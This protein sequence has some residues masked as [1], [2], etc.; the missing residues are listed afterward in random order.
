MIDE[1]GRYTTYNTIEYV[2][3]KNQSD[4]IFFLQN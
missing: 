1:V 2:W 4:N 3:A